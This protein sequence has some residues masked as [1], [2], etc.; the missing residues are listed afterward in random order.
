MLMFYIFKLNQVFEDKF[1]YIDV[2]NNDVMDIL[3]GRR[4]IEFDYFVKMMKQG[5]VFCKELLQFVSCVSERKY[6]LV[7]LFY[8]KCCKCGDINCV[9]SGKRQNDEKNGQGFFNVN[10]K[11]GVGVYKNFIYKLDCII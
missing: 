7:S 4:I 3:Y 5:C 2:N 6:G 8:I 11:L 9:V 1:L 10:V